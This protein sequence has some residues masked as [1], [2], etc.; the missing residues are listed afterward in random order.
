MIDID[1]FVEMPKDVEAKDFITVSLNQIEKLP[2][3]FV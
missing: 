2:E 1:S 3:A